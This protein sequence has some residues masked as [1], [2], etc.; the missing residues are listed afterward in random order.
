MGGRIITKLKKTKQDAVLQVKMTKQVVKEAATFKAEAQDVEEAILKTSKVTVKKIRKIFK[1]F[2]IICGM[3]QSDWYANLTPEGQEQAVKIV[4]EE[5]HRRQVW[6]GI[7]EFKELDR[8]IK[9]RTQAECRDKK[10]F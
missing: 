6:C 1:K 2:G 5:V 8:I 10:G 7:K 4:H 9:V 3:L